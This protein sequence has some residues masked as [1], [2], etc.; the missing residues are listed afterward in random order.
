MSSL[1]EI[2]VKREI[3]YIHLRDQ[4]EK[5]FWGSKQARAYR[6]A[7]LIAFNAE[8]KVFTALKNN[9]NAR[10]ADY[11]VHFRKMQEIVDKYMRIYTDEFNGGINAYHLTKAEA[12]RHVRIVEGKLNELT[13]TIRQYHQVLLNAGHSNYYYFNADSLRN[14]IDKELKETLV[15]EFCHIKETDTWGYAMYVRKIYEHYKSFD[16]RFRLIKA[17]SPFD[18]FR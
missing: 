4:I 6:D 13:Q 17:N 7:F 3:E 15:Y 14:D 2:N 5:D 9:A 10:Q 12:Q 11:D 1:Y 8:H 18:L 16:A